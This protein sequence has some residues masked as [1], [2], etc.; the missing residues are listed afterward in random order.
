MAVFLSIARNGALLLSLS[1]VYSLLIPYLKRRPALGSLITG[2]LFGLFAVLNMLEPMQLGGA[3]V[4]A[5]NTILFMAALTGGYRAGIIALLIVTGYRASLGI[6]GF[7]AGWMSMLCGTLMGIAFRAYRLRKAIPAFRFDRELVLLSILLAVQSLL[8]TLILP[9]GRGWELVPVLALPVLL[10]FPSVTLIMAWLIASAYQRIELSAALQESEARLRVIFEQ[11]LQFL[12]LMDADGT[13]RM[14]SPSLIRRSRLSETDIIGKKFWEITWPNLPEASLEKLKDA[15]K[16]S[17]EGLLS[18]LSLELSPPDGPMILDVVFQKI[19]DNGQIL[20]ESRDITA[21]MLGE[22]RRLELQFERERNNILQQLISDAS[23]HLRTP[24]SILTS[25]LYLLQKQSEKA[26]DSPEWQSKMQGQFKKL[27]NA[28]L[29]LVDIVEDLL[30]MMKLDSPDTFHFEAIS[31]VPYLSETIDNYYQIAEEKN[32]SLQASIPASSLQVSIAAENFRRVVA[33]LIENALR[34]TP[35]GGTVNLSLAQRGEMLE[36]V[37]QDTGIG[38]PAEDLPRIF[39]RFFRAKNASSQSQKGTGL[40][41]AIVK[42]T[43]EMHKGKIEI[44]SELGKGTRVTIL[45]PL[46][47][48]SV[49]AAS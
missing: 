4:D 22:K 31:F 27:D 49:L 17:N 37:V 10:I 13:V 46:L 8:W 21:Q 19:G 48:E 38:I 34:Y 24:L 35:D 5:R 11:S 33:N 44:S 9:N 28:R 16:A 25:S 36:F 29:E 1:F 3:V 20:M 14:T 26:S 42:K 2:F 45:I 30:S 41:L 23:H 32:I 15:I 6:E 12:C 39:D 43:V 47:N 40:G 18:R 7:L